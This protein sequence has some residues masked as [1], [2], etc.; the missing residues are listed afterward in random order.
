M[1]RQFNTTRLGGDYVNV[2]GP[3]DLSDEDISALRES[4]EYIDSMEPEKKAVYQELGNSK[5]PIHTSDYVLDEV[6]TLLFRRESFHE[7]THFMDGIFAA[8]ALGQVRI[9]RVTTDRF[10]EACQLRKRFQDK[11][12]ISFTD[13]VSMVIMRELDIRQVLTEDEH[14]V[15]VGMGFS[16]LP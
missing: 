4:M 15:Q 9:E 16:R 8:A 3:S 14:F 1:S 7:A 10:V 6:I 13:L 12:K 2:V 11:P 5:I